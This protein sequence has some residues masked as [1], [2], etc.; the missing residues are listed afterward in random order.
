MIVKKIQIYKF[1]NIQMSLFPSFLFKSYES[2]YFAPP[3]EWN[4]TKNKN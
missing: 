1:K 3:L 2:L 4:V